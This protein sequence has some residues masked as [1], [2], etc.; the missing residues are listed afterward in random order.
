MK[1]F[2]WNVY[3][4]II[5][6]AAV[7]TITVFI[8][9]MFTATTVTTISTPLAIAVFIFVLVMDILRDDH[10]RNGRED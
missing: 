3:Q 9:A 8:Q 4:G 2:L 1:T 10:L 5:C 7:V 6:G